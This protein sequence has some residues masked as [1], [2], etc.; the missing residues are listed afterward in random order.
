[1]N[2]SSPS[3]LP[4]D[5]VLTNGVIYTVDKKRS[6]A[7]AM[8]VKGDTFVYVGDDKG[9][10]KWIGDQ[11]RLINLQGKLVLPGL[12]DAHNHAIDATFELFEVVLHGLRS[13]DEYKQA[14]TDFMAVH[15]GTRGILGG[16]WMNPL[17]PPEGPTKEIL[18]ELAT[19]IPVVLWSEDYHSVWVN[20]KALEMGGVTK[21]TPNPTGGIIEKDA[22]GN[23]NGTLRESAANLVEEVIPAYTV[24]QLIEG[25]KYFQD[26]AH[27]YGITTV[28][29]PGIKIGSPQLQSLRKLEDSGELTVRFRGALSV[30]PADDP[31]IVEQFAQTREQDKGGLFE[32]TAAKIFMDGVVE[33]STAYLE[34]PYVHKPD[35]RG[36]PV[37]DGQKFNL[38]C[39]ALEKAGFQIHVHSIGDAATRF[40]LDGFA[41]AR[42]QN[43]AGD[44]RHM[45]THLQLVRPDDILRFA[46]LG[47]V[48]V[49]QPYWFLVDL[50]YT[51]AVEYLGKERADQQYP[52]KSFF[53]NNVVVAS[54]SDYNVTVPPNPLVAIETG[55]TRKWNDS[56]KSINSDP[57]TALNP[58][59]MVSLDEM[60]ASFT[61]NGAYANFLEDVTG[62]LEVGK[63][64]DFIVLDKNLFEIPVEEIHTAAVLLTYFEG[65]EVYRSEAYDE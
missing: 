4:A 30:D 21:D 63:K 5:L 45:I 37:W 44:R 11:T 62:S 1:M 64:A 22:V 6:V 8:A 32:I 55:I 51:Q 43:G 57:E 26:M 16:G 56:I 53:A 33:G 14:I 2:H 15:P 36:E 47:V 29:I 50:H 17:F 42:E 10:A 13:V 25:L 58:A 19:D 3:F 52:M 49:V 38:M 59:E 31:T 54:A 20:S 27:S 48:A 39:T 7:S 28:H 61:I 41:Y 35:S 46:D 23:P 9:A 60:I 65:A 18:D 34:Q 40:T 12:F 24:D